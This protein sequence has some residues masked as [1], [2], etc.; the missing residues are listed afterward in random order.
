MNSI[1]TILWDLDGTL[2]DTLEDLTDGVNHALFAFGYPPR[3]LEEIRSFVGNGSRKLIT[4]CLPEH[5]PEDQLEAVHQEFQ[6]Y[7]RLHA[8]IKTKPFAGILPLLKRLKEAG[9]TMSVVSNKPHAAVVPLVG[10]YFGDLF[11]G[12]TG[13][14]AGIPRKPAKDMIVEA[15]HQ[16][17]A[18][19]KRTVYVG[20]SEVDVLTA[21]N[22]SLPCISVCWGFRD[23]EQLSAAGATVL[24]RNM[25]ELEA[26]LLG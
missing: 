23:P 2:L 4:C 6:R 3:S 7:Y 26:A 9:I 14:K 8:Q 5:T 21:K 16:L 11:Q 22:A 19:P 17:G 18:D 12:A 20:D 1:Q 13:E 15:I 25:E 24:C 10:Q